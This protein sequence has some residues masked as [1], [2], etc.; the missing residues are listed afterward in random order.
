[1]QPIFA[2]GIGIEPLLYVLYYVVVILL[3]VL[4]VVLALVLL[5]AVQLVCGSVLLAIFGKKRHLFW[6]LPTLSLLGYFI[7][8]PALFWHPEIDGADYALVTLVAV[9]V[10]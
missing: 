3:V 7:L 1:M 9:P 5:L 4:A 2:H 6:S 10:L 8:S